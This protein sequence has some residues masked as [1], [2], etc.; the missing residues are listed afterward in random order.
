MTGLRVTGDRATA[1][2]KLTVEHRGLRPRKE[3]ESTV[4]RTLLILLILA[5]AHCAATPPA[6]G[7]TPGFRGYTALMLVPTADALMQ[8]EWNAG[9][10]S[11]NVSSET[12]NSWI[13]NYGLIDNLEVGFNRYDPGDD[14]DDGTWINA[15]YE[16]FRTCPERFGLAVGI[17]DLLDETDTTIYIV[18]SASLIERPAVW[19]GEILAPRIHVGFG[20]GMLD[21]LFAGFSTWLGNRF[22]IM[23]EWDGEAVNAGIKYRFTPNLTL[24]AGGLNLSEEELPGTAL[25]DEAGFGLGL[26]YNYSY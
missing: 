10:F 5:L 26:S 2:G 22:Q 17:I 6:Y 9:V 25:D 18:G 1:P 12:I 16:F 13:A 24:H 21:S 3:G 14:A 8:G 15:K 19:Y 4:S 11:E 23:G 20:A 7:V